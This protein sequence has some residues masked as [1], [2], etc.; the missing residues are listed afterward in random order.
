MLLICIDMSMFRK[1]KSLSH[2]FVCQDI[3][4]V[5]SLNVQPVFK[6]LFVV[7]LF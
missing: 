3:L 7:S 2:V 1:Y 6:D 4:S 5:Q